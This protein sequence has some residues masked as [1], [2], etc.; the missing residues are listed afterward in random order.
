LLALTVLL[1]AADAAAVSDKATA[2][3]RLLT[4]V[5]QH[6]II[7]QSASTKNSAELR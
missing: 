3:A 7:R 6:Q 4:A 1:E 5:I 2:A